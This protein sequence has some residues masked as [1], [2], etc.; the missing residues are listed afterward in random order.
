MLEVKEENVIR[1]VRSTNALD[2]ELDHKVMFWYMNRLEIGKSL[3]GAALAIPVFFYSPVL[4][5]LA[6]PLGIFIGILV[7]SKWR[8]NRPPS[9]MWDSFHAWGLIG[10]RSRFLKR[11]KREVILTPDAKPCR[12]KFGD[13][14]DGGLAMTEPHQMLYGLPNWGDVDER[15][16][17]LKSILKLERHVAARIIPEWEQG[18]SEAPAYWGRCDPHNWESD[19]DMVDPKIPYQIVSIPYDWRKDET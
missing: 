6:M 16:K 18:E 1:L 2:K 9:Y 7:I 11:T 13:T 19:R 14:R 10:D 12:S 3:L 5:A 4:F 15:G 17:P 8:Y